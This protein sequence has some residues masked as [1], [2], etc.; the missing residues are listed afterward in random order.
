MQLYNTMSR[1][2]EDFVP[3]DK[4]EVGVYTCGPTVYHDAHL[5]NMRT[6]IFSDTLVRLMRSN[7]YNVKHVMNITDVGHLTSDADEGPDKMELGATR[8]GRTAWE[9]AET[10]EERFLEQC[11]LL[12]IV[13]PTILCRATEH[14]RQQIQMIERLESKGFVYRTD[15]G[16][17]FD[18]S[19]VPD[20][21]RLARL[22]K[23]GLR[24]GIRVAAGGKRNKTDFALWKLSPSGE[25]RQMEW[26]SPWGI[27]FPGWHIECSAMSTFYLGN[28]FD[29]HTGG[30]DHIPVHHSNEIAQSECATNCSPFV[31]YWM[32]ANF[33]QMEN[34]ERM[35]KSK[36]SFT[37]TFTLLERG[38]DP[39]A[40]RFLCMKSHY[41]NT[42]KFSM[43][44]LEGANTA[45]RRL[46]TSILELGPLQEY[47]SEVSLDERARAYKDNIFGALNNDLGTPVALTHLQAL[48]ADESIS[49]DQRRQVVDQVDDVF[50]LKFTE[51]D[52]V[53]SFESEIPLAVQELATLRQAARLRRDWQAADK[54]RQA[55]GDSG[56]T[57]EDTTEGYKIS[58]KQQPQ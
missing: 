9:V 21:G 30:I 27:G 29:I 32:H 20:Y 31:R 57:V 22:D 16:V 13:P 52:T 8:E 5:G 46:K 40:F 10:Y 48:V 51:R 45:F 38:I 42:M 47:T 58:R 28:Q 23:E 55:I 50:G 4:D 6:Y 18:T 33:L 24:E 39:L 54:L 14:I 37:T 19:L 17:Y 7:G 49:T 36:G 11:G 43:E 3:L 35:A 25:K 2:V 34:D 41:R 26:P 53:H 56:Y 44:I 1:A 15:D 12:N